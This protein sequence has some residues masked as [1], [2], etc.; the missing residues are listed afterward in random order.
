MAKMTKKGREFV[1][2]EIS[3]LM[4]EGPS[5][6]PQKD[7]PMKQDQAVAVALN[8]ARKKGFKAPPNPNESLDR[9]PLR[10]IGEAQIRPSGGGFSP[11]MAD[12]QRKRTERIRQQKM[13]RRMS[14][15]KTGKPRT[16]G[17][18]T[19]PPPPSPST[20]STAAAHPPSRTA[21]AMTP[22]PP[23][24]HSGPTLRRAML[25]KPAQHP[26]VG[27]ARIM[28]HRA[29]VGLQQRKRRMSAGVFSPEPSGRAVHS[30]TGPGYNEDRSNLNL[31]TKEETMSIFDSLIERELPEAFKKNMGRFKIGKKADDASDDAGDDAGAVESTSVF[32]DIVQESSP[33]SI[34]DGIVQEASK[35]LFD[36]IVESQD[37]GNWE[38]RVARTLVLSEQLVDIRRSIKNS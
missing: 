19:P 10:T 12:Q 11:N 28:G 38:D 26:A 27:A 36:D 21:G 3:H 33:A 23:P 8:V 29:K 16:L 14:D 7:Q 35:S 24:G 13:Q 9:S 15:P 37:A 18:S 4:K 20:A 2:D 31:I 34:F 5:K 22:A 17:P 32:D 30:Q 6:G 1:S 25:P